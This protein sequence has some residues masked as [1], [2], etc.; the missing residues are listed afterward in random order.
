MK[1][2]LGGTLALV[3][4]G[5][6]Y[7]YSQV[8]INNLPAHS[9]FYKEV[10]D[11]YENAGKVCCGLIPA[12]KTKM[13]E[14]YD[15][16]DVGMYCIGYDNPDWLADI[17]KC[18]SVVGHYAAAGVAQDATLKTI[19]TEAKLKEAKI[20]A[21]DVLEINANFKGNYGL[22]FNIC[23]HALILK[24]CY[25]YCK[26]CREKKVKGMPVCEIVNEQGSRLFI[27]TPLAIKQFM[28]TTIPDPPMNAKGK[29]E[30][31][32]YGCPCNVETKTA[33]Q[34][35]PAAQPK[36]AD[37]KS[38]EAPKPVVQAPAPAPKPVETPKPVVQ[39]PVP[40]PAPKPVAQAPAPAPKP[41]VQ[42]FAAQPKPADKPK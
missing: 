11:T 3:A 20:D 4:G 36:P 13:K 14:K 16:K 17:K 18:R 15:K 1:L 21:C 7:L 40:A 34:P 22:Y 35:K 9:I 39:A 24:Y 33:E 28:L 12:L 38:V 2:V 29:E 5:V 27:P 31:K 23:M 30:M 19:V 6:G 37:L 10:Q 8:N 42:A 26:E 25:K 41:T 32:K